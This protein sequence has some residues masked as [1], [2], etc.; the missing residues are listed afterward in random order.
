MY[1]DFTPY[2]SD[3][4]VASVP[5]SSGDTFYDRGLACSSSGAKMDLIEAHKW[6][7][8]AASEGNPCGG[9]ARASVALDMTLSEVAEAQ[10]RARQHSDHWVMASP[11]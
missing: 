8:L 10:R 11:C 2:F 4:S 9:P 3:E 7:N 1:S 6:F 5:P